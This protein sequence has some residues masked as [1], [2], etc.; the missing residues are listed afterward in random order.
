MSTAS[1]PATV[2][3]EAGTRAPSRVWVRIRR[4]AFWVVCLG[5]VAFNA[6]WLARDF[7]PIPDISAIRGMMAR[8]DVGGAERALR[9]YLGRSPRHGEAR[10]L[11]AQI[12][13]RRGD[14]LGC[15]EELGRIPFWWPGK[16]EAL[17]LEGQAYRQLHMARRAEAAFR[18]CVRYDPLHPTSWNY[19]RGAAQ[20]L[21]ALYVLEGRRDEAR[22]VIWDAYR[23]AKDVAPGDRAA[24]LATRIRVEIEQI[25]PPEAVANLRR[26]V[27]ADANDWDARRALATALQA[28]GDAPAADREIAACL[29]A[30]PSKLANWRAWLAILQV[31]NDTA[32][33]SEAVSRMPTAVANAEDSTIQQ[34]RGM[35]LESR[36]DLEGALRAYDEAGRVA[37]YDEEV[38]FRLAR[39]EQR[40]GRTRDAER[41]R[42]RHKV[43]REARQSL[44]PAYT[45]Y[46]EAWSGGGASLP[47]RDRAT[48]RLAAICETLGW[49]QVAGELRTLLS[50]AWTSAN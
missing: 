46:R 15:A 31:R 14:S 34:C 1:S 18:A 9:A 26:N 6:W 43:L 19:V 5:L 17:F 35:V 48:D 40:L 8:G 42:D 10:M 12:L 28:A 39:V 20:E 16:R 11:L 21:I 23:E 49:P 3:L 38:H 36:G 50:P 33:L 27:E 37:P 2:P 7:W 32:R 25:K 47:E 41:H 22:E 29:E 13:A 4:G 44:A 45:T 30:E 24:I